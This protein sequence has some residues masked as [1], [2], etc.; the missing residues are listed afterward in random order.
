M[1]ALNADKTGSPGDGLLETKQKGAA[2]AETDSLQTK[3]L[4]V[5]CP[6]EL[7]VLG[8]IAPLQRQIPTESN[9]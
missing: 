4:W 7:P 6:G 5:E 2:I 8:W 1:F 9:P 3:I